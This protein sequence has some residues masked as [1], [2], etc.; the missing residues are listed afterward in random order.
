LV[1]R[2]PKGYSPNEIYW[3]PS[4]GHI[5]THALENTDVV[6]HL[7]GKSIATR[8]TRARKKAI[9]DSRVKST[10]VLSEALAKL[11]KP[12]YLF[13]CASAIGYYGDRG[14]EWLTEDSK[15]GLGFAASLCRDWESAS[16]SAEHVGIKVVHL[17]FGTVLDASGGVIKRL[18]PSFRLGLGSIAGTGEQYVSWI[19][20]SD[21]KRAFD[22]IIQNRDL[23]GPINLSSPNPVPVQILMTTI[24]HQ[25]HRPCAIFVPEWA[26]RLLFGQMGEELL[27][28]SARATPKKLL[29]S[30]FEFELAEIDAAIHSVIR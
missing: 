5:E 12:P 7:N 3:N 21:V 6:I 26:I 29:Q 23:E 22:Y 17:R 2:Q 13:I 8:W 9:H 15:P 11:K 24:A 27:L 25:L 30:G 20:L 14:D 16:I 18:L 4:S 19:A 28:Y 10:R 1:R